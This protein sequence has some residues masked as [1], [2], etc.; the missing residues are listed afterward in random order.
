MYNQKIVSASETEEVKGV[1][2][3]KCLKI[4]FES[5]MDENSRRDI[6]SRLVSMKAL[7]LSS[8]YSEEKAKIL[9]QF[10]QQVDEK[11][12]QLEQF[13]TAL[14]INKLHLDNFDYL[15]LPKQLLECCASLSVN[16]KL[17]KEEIPKAVRD[18]EDAAFK[19]K[20]ELEQIE[21]MVEEEEKE[22]RTEQ[23]KDFSSSSDDDDDDEHNQNEQNS[24]KVK[25][26]RISDKYTSMLK[27]YQDAIDSN[28]ALTDAFG[29]ISKN[30]EILLLPLTELTE[31]LP[32]VEEVEDVG[33]KEKLVSLLGKVDEMRSQRLE[34]F[35]RLQ[36]AL[37]DDDLTKSIAGKQNEIEKPE[38]FFSEQ[39]KKHESLVSYLQQN[40]TAQENILRALAEANAAFAADRKK[41]LDATQQRNAFIDGLVFSYQSAR[42]LVDKAEKGLA[43]FNK[44]SQ[45][46]EALKKET[47]E[48]CA[49]EKNDR[50]VRKKMMQR[51]QMMS[52]FVP[53][54]SSI[55]IGPT[56]NRPNNKITEVTRPEINQVTSQTAGMNLGDRPKLKDFLPFMKPSSWAQSQVVRPP[57]L[58][59][60]NLSTSAP[61]IPIV[62]KIEPTSPP[63]NF[64]QTNNQQQNISNFMQNFPQNFP[65]KNSTNQSQQ[66][67]FNPAMK[68]SNYPP[69]MSQNQPQLQSQP[70]QNLNPSQFVPQFHP[71]QS[72]SPLPQNHQFIS[73]TFQPPSVINNKPN[74]QPINT[75]PQPTQIAQSNNQ[76]YIPPP[77]PSL[78]M[79]APQLPQFQSQF[80]SGQ[81]VL[82]K[83]LE[84]MK[85]KQEEEL[86][87][88]QQQIKERELELQ[89]QREQFM[90]QQQQRQFP[91][92]PF[93]QPQPT[94]QAP[95]PPTQI[96]QPQQGPVLFQQ[97]QMSQQMYQSNAFPIQQPIQPMNQP[98]AYFNPVPHQIRPNQTVT[99]QPPPPPAAIAEPPAAKQP[100]AIDDLLGI[101]DSNTFSASSTF[102]V[103]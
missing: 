84:E 59:Q 97:A 31:K 13:L 52:G 25:I 68:P 15:K 58:Q 78:Q 41:I 10:G 103:T 48:F 76:V 74:Q 54:Q 40:L 82:S 63:L 6:F 46:I 94:L 62:P 22:H 50:E 57:Q 83:N 20:N 45:S 16:P 80:A 11:N 4:D 19:V 30:L 5:E 24:R 8:I 51:M 98:S 75:L 73:P 43:F 101:F 71:P 18:L 12:Q 77:Q 39:L 60:P 21:K 91:T 9:R 14:Q 102:Q 81:I 95:R 2:L 36:K 44:L 79:S 33:A 56:F 37:H 34:L 93:S 53:E 35:S 38:E 89:R 92:H 90:I 67:Y 49:K 3:V 64:P 65:E 26:R 7:E 66:S 17:A 42:D 61:T 32:I 87:V 69:Q 55:Q 29:S 23:K 88:M 96:I 99:P 28:L 100:S 70:T 86:R 72:S 1:S 27:S 85:R 47:A